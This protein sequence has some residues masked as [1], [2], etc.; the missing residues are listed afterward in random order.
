VLRA[1]Y[2][3]M[4]DSEASAYE[5]LLLDVLHGDHM[6]FF[7]FD[8]VEWSWRIVEPIVQAWKHGAPEEYVSGSSG[9]SGQHRSSIPATIGA[10]SC[11]PPT[12]ESGRDHVP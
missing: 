3:E 1:L 4:G 12:P 8:E 6:P 2:T 10:R 5:S 7:R 11:T 9:P